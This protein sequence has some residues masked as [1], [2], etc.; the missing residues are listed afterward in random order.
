MCI[1]SSSGDGRHSFL[2]RRQDVI[3]SAAHYQQRTKLQ[4]LFPEASLMKARGES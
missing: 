3:I 4:Q 1:S 2:S